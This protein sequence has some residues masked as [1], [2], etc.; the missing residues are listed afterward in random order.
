[1]S[2][3][4]HALGQ[5]RGLAPEDEGERARRSASAV[6][7]LRVH[8]RRDDPDAVRAKPGEG[9]LRGRG[10]ERHGERRPDAGPDRRSG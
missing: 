5:A 9:L 6:G 8:P 7:P 2:G 4:S 10:G 1:M 3:A